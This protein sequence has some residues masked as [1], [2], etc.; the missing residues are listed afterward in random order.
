MP[1]IFLLDG[2]AGSGRRTLTPKIAEH[3]GAQL[4]HFL[5]VTTR[6][7]RADD[8]NYIYMDQ[9]EF[10]EH[11][12]LKEFAAS[13]KFADGQSYGVLR[14]PIEEALEKGF[15]AYSL[16]DLGTVNQLR[17]C[18]PDCV[19]IFLIAPIEELRQRLEKKGVL[20]PEQLEE[21]LTNAQAAFSKAAYYDYV[22]PNRN[23]QF[24]KVANHII[25]IM[26]REIKLEAKSGQK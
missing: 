24:E 15:H 16:M 22:V 26:E 21:R 13:R 12:S 17:R 7:P 18:W 23:G 5:R 8:K 14:T 2:P 3:F 10:A 4:K 1:R 11:D 9:I 6:P 19:T 25:H 20:T